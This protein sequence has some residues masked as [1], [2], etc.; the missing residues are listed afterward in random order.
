MDNVTEI[1]IL[2]VSVIITAI[3]IIAGFSLLSASR[4]IPSTMVSQ[5]NETNQVMENYQY[6]KYLDKK[7]S[8]SDALSAA[9]RLWNKGVT[10]RLGFVSPAGALMSVVND[11]TF[12]MDSFQNLPTNAIY[13]NPADGYDA[14]IGYN[15]NGTIGEINFRCQEHSPAV[16]AAPLSLDSYGS[17]LRSEVRDEGAEGTGSEAGSDGVEAEKLEDDAGSDGVEAEELEDGAES[18]GVEAGK[19]EDETESDG[20]E[21]GSDGVKAEK[22]EEEEDLDVIFSDETDSGSTETEESAILKQYRTELS[23]LQDQFDK[24]DL[25]S[26]EDD[27]SEMLIQSKID[28]LEVVKGNVAALQIEYTE[29]NLSA[30]NKKF[31]E[32]SSDALFDKIDDVI[33]GLS[34]TSTEEVIE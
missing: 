21:A 28:E 16:V 14:S 22:S 11:G 23:K 2:A 29:K 33:G 20:A 31:V 32:Q 9:R 27:P 15:A 1:I 7:L 5:L 13:I 12:D 8:G 24:V 30:D 4:A 3:V 26:L 10:V 19:L 25:K 17:G 18:D 6:T 34:M